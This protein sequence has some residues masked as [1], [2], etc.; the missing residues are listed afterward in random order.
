ME[1]LG[2][3]SVVGLTDGDRSSEE[4]RLAVLASVGDHHHLV[5]AMVHHRD[6]HHIVAVEASEEEAATEAGPQGDR[7]ALPW[8]AVAALHH[9]PPGPRCEGAET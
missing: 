4:D 1:V 9:H 6:P 7:R 2:L 3:A 8:A 5:E